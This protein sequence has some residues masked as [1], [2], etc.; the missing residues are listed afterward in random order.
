MLAGYLEQTRGSVSEA[1]SLVFM[2]LGVIFLLT[3]LYHTRFMPRSG[4]DRPM[5]G[6]TPS[7]IMRD[8]ARTFVTFF[9]KPDIVPALLFMLFYRLP[10]A[11]CLKLVQPFLVS[12]REEGRSGTFYFRSRICKRN[13]RCGRASCRRHTRRYRH[14]ARRIEKMAM[15]MA[16]S[17]TLPCVF[18]CGLAMWQ[19]ENFSLICAA[20]F[21]EQ[22]GYGF[23]FT[24]FMLY[25]I[26]FSRG[27]SK[28]SHYAF[29]TAFMALGM[30]LPGMAAGWLHD[31]FSG[32]DIYGDGTPQG[33]V[34]FFLAGDALLHSYIRCLSRSENRT[35]F[36]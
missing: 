27:E 13:R 19:P 3:A 8:F 7:T 33:Y 17:L 29:C 24:A 12:P 9:R 21:T 2:L 18:Y 30:M 10:E 35:R 6:V 16:L 1:W 34:N 14:I 28:T 4:E 20:I 25:L 23:G 22:F 31:I 32:I 15:V 26:Y 5:P 36:R 11:M